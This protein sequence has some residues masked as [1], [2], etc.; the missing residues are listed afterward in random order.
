MHSDPLVTLS[1]LLGSWRVPRISI[2]A[3]GI[4]AADVA[5]LAEQYGWSR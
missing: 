2:A 5:R 4:K 3:H 1:T